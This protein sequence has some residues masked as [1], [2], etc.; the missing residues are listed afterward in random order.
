MQVLQ[1]SEKLKSDFGNKKYLIGGGVR[2][3]VSIV[4]LQ[5][6]AI[7]RNGLMISAQ[8]ALPNDLIDCLLANYMR[9]EDPIG[10]N[11]LLK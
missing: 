3:F 11:G 8:K 6:A 1:S 5:E 7:F 2:N 4:I 10:E 9:Q